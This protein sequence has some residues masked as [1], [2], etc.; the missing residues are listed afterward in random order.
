MPP[1][2][3]ASSKKS[4]PTGSAATSDEAERH[5]R[6][7]P[8]DG[9]ATLARLVLERDHDRQAGADHGRRGHRPRLL[10]REVEGVAGEQVGGEDAECRRRAR[11]GSRSGRPR[12]GSPPAATGRWTGPGRGR[13]RGSRSSSEE[14]RVNW[15]GSSGK[16]PLGSAIVTSRKA[17]KIA[18]LTKSRATRWMLRRIWRPSWTSGGTSPNS[19]ETRTRSETERAICVPRALGDRQPR[20]LQRRHVVDAVAEHADVLA[21]LGQHPHHARLVLGRD[22]ADRRRRP[23]RRQQLLVVLR[24][25]AA[26][27]RR[28]FGRRRRRR[29][30]SP[31]PSP[32]CRRRAP[33]ARPPRRRRRRRSRRRSARSCSART[34]IPSGRSGRGSGASGAG[35]GSG[36]SAARQRQHAAARRRPRRRRARRSG[37]VAVLTVEQRLRR[38]EHQPFAVQLERAPA[39]PR[40]ERDR[41][42][43]LDRRHRRRPAAPRG[44]PPGSRLRERRA[45]RVERQRPRQLGLRRRRPPAPGRPPAARTRSASR[46]CR[47]TS[48]RPR[49]AT[50]SRSAAGRGSRAAPSSPP[51]P[52]RSA[53]RAGSGPRGRC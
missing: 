25:R 35:S 23:H 31:R 22:A 29:G 7:E 49:P 8:G 9:A 15:R 24:Q 43:R 51:R 47:C 14:V 28:R 53:R 33:S 42:A 17:V 41:G 27:E 21:A 11:P 4:R 6:A 12:A 3:G 38:A 50:R 32:G 44:P 30:R 46:S 2:G 52:R 40:G 20:L 48:P 13:R 34:T 16:T 39:P 5:Q 26:V 1:V 18:L 19:P 10:E 37:A 36:A 45:R